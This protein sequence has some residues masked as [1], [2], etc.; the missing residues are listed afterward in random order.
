M[1]S[2]PILSEINR[3]LTVSGMSRTAFGHESLGDPNLISDLE[4]GRELRR[5][6]R[7]R[8]MALINKIAPPDPVFTDSPVSKRR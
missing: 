6:A 7:D 1:T 3:A 2:D 4:K 8:V 5:A